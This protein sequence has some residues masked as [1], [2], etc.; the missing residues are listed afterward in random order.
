M[1][2]FCLFAQVRVDLVNVG[3]IAFDNDSDGF[4]VSEFWLQLH[5][6]MMIKFVPKH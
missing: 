1:G 4:F 6:L 5:L 2:T 3:A